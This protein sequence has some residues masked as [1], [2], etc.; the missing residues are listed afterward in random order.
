MIQNVFFN[1]TRNS[2]N[3]RFFLVLMIHFAFVASYSKTDLHL[4]PLHLCLIHIE[5]CNDTFFNYSV[6]IFEVQSWTWRD[7]NS[8][9]SRE[10]KVLPLN[11]WQAKFSRHMSCKSIV[12]KTSKTSAHTQNKTKKSSSNNPTFH[13]LNLKIRKKNFF[14]GSEK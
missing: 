1:R 2:T 12:I 3:M 11:V 8:K 7:F 4:T 9:E 10:Q 14:F 13:L 6:L 5:N